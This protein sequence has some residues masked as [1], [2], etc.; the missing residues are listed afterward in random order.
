MPAVPGAEPAQHRVDGAEDARGPPARG[1]PCR[2]RRTR[3]ARRRSPAGAA[4]GRGTAGRR[5]HPAGTRSSSGQHSIISPA[6][7]ARAERPAAD[8]GDRGSGPAAAGVLMRSRPWPRQ[9]R[10]DLVDAQP[11]RSED[12]G[13]LRGER[14]RLGDH[15]RRAGPAETTS[16]SASTTT[17]S[18]TWA[19]NS[20]S[21]VATRTAWPVVGEVAHDAR[22]AA[23]WRRSRAR[24]SARRAAAPR[25]PGGEHDGQRQRE[26]LALGEVARVVAP[27]RCPARA[28]RAGPGRSRARGAAGRRPRTPRRRSRGRAGR[29][30]SAAPARRAP[31]GRAASRLGR[32]GAGHR[33]RRRERRLPAPCSAQSSVDLPEPLRPIS[34]VTV[35]RRAASTSTSRTA[36]VRPWVTVTPLGVEQRP[37]APAGGSRPGAASVA[38]VARAGAGRRARSAAAGTSRRPGRARRA[39]ARPGESA[40]SSRGLVRPGAPPSPVSRRDPVGERHHPLEPVLGEQHRERRGRGPGGSGWPAPPR[41]RSGRGRRWARRAPG[42]AGAW[43]APSRWRRAAARRPRGV[44]RSR[45]RRSA[46]P[47]RSRVSSTRRRMVSGG[48][49]ELL[50]AVGELLLDGVGDEPGGRVLADVPDRGGRA[51]AA[52]SHDAHAVEQHVAGEP[53]AGEARHQPGDA[54]RAAWTCR[55]RCGPE[56][57]DQLALLEGQVDA[58][59]D[60]RVRR[61]SGSRCRAARSRAP[62][63][64]AGASRR[65][66]GGGGARRRAAAPEHADEGERLTGRDGV[67]AGVGRPARRGAGP[68]HQHRD[69]DG[70]RTGRRAAPAACHESGR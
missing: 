15:R 38:Q 31:G 5:G 26:P 49:A 13:D 27:G 59:E 69:R 8:R 41:R 47:S 39:A 9:R 68:P 40:S 17:S 45:A 61:R 28:G 20:T 64:R 25:G 35:A 63:P 62:P 4:R 56:T 7:E 65:R 66:R 53:A 10:R 23:P 12:L 19:T 70:D 6:S 43:S 2:P 29:R 18:A 3:R 32:V 46:M 44:R 67:D 30:R 37:R 55:R 50:H 48:S 54:R 52:G 33:D 42:A 24:G 36:T 14:R 11:G 58:V 22:R 21:W 57:S 1:R 60:G 34:A 51:R 16:P